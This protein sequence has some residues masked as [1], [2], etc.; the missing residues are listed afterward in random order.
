MMAELAQQLVRTRR[1]RL[2]LRDTQSLLPLGQ[3]QSKALIFAAAGIA[4]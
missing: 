4:A 1:I 3:G 2:F